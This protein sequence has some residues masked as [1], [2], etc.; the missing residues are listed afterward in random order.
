MLLP[1]S[2]V[3]LSGGGLAYKEAAKG[4]EPD[5][6]CHNETGD[7]EEDDAFSHDSH[8][9]KT[10]GSATKFRPRGDRTAQEISSDNAQAVLPPPACVFV[11]K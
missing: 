10:R 3:R 4:A 9:S 11:A 6:S 7:E 8:E 1:M 5:A 2:N